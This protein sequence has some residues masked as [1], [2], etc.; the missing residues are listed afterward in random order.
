M[1]FTVP[2]RA[3]IGLR[4]RMLTATQGRAVMHHNLF[5][6]EPIRGEVPQRP[7]GVLV[8]SEPG[9]VTA[10]ALDALFDRGQFFVM[11]GEV[12]YEG[13]VVGEH[14]KASD[15]IVNVVR[16][17]KLTNIRAAGKDDSAQVRPAREMSLEVCLEYIQDDELVE[18]T[19]KSIRLRKMVLKESDRRRETRRAKSQAV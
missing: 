16:E 5:R 19:P 6:Y 15:L 3:L 14:C 9:M 12:V 10:Y 11:P 17:K 1:T 8:A 18:I 13:Q 7:A 2:A 4:S